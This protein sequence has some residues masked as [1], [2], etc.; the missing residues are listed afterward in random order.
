[1]LPVAILGSEDFDVTEV[2]VS[3]LTLEGVAPIRSN[4][5]DVSTPVE[6]SED[7]C[8]C[9]EKGPDGFDDLTLKF[10]KQAIVDALGAVSGGDEV[11]LTLAGETI[12][13]TPL[14]GSDCVVITPAGR[15]R[16]RAKLAGGVPDSY[17]LGQNVPNPSNPQTQIS[18]QLP[19]AGEVSLVIY[20]ALGQPIRTLV[21]ERQAAGVYRVTWDGRDGQ[22]RAVSSGVYLYRLRA[23]SFEAERKMVLAK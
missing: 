16:G 5:E 22:G 10:D 19:E 20:N 13:G 7:E 23:G 3:S 12:D 9:T 11:V 1:M 4:I 2:D 6:D 17:G 15:G 8:A 18:Y 14:E 21:Q